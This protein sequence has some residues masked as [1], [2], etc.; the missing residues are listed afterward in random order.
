MGIPLVVQW[1]GLGIF[2]AMA[3]VQS[4]FMEL[5]SHKLLSVTTNKNWCQ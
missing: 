4:L 1:L 3:Q 5:R 2:S